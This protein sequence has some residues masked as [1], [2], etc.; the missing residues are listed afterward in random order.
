MNNIYDILGII[1]DFQ[2]EVSAAVDA[3]SKKSRTEKHIK[4]MTKIGYQIPDF[5]TGL[6][7]MN[8]SGALSF[9]RELRGNIVLLDFF[10]YCCVNCLHILPDLEAVE[11]KYPEGTGV[12]V[13][14]VHSAKFLN[15]KVTANITSAV[16][17][18]GIK[19]PVVN[20][21]GASLWQSLAVSCWPTVLIIGPGGQLLHSLAG[22][23][24]RQSMLD[25]LDVAVEMF[26]SSGQLQPSRIPISL[27]SD[28]GGHSD[29]SFPGKVRVWREKKWLLIS[30]SGNHRVVVVDFNGVVQAVV[31]S[32]RRGF[33][34][35]SLEE[36]EFSSPQG[37]DVFD[38]DIY[39]ADTDNHAVRRI[40]L[41]EQTVTTVSGTGRQGADLEGGKL[42]TQQELS[43]PWDLVVAHPEIDG[44]MVPVLFLAMSG[45]HQVWVYFLKD[46]GWLKNRSYEK[47]TCL[48][49]AGSGKEENRNNAYPEKAGFAQP[50]GLAF[51]SSGSNS[52]LYIADSES[53][54]V[55]TISLPTGK[56]A[57]LVGAEKDPTN[58]FAYGDEDGRG[59][60]AKLQHPLGV[61][62]M[63]ATE[64]PL[65]IADSYNH[66]IK[67]VDLSLA[68]CTTLAGTGKPG[69]AA[70]SLLEESQFN[71]PGGVCVDEGSKTIYVADTNNHAIKVI[72]YSGRSVRKLPIVFPRETSKDVQTED[73]DVDSRDSKGDGHVEVLPAVSCDV[74]RSEVELTVPVAV[75]DG[76]HI[77]SEAPNGWSVQA[78]D[79][80]GEVH[81]TARGNINFS[82]NGKIG[83]FVLKCPPMSASKS[84]TLK[85]KTQ[86]FVCLDDGDVCLPPRNCHFD[87]NLIL[88]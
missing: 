60:S 63:S 71:E 24:H 76:E 52:T 65:I 85:I 42:F 80:T 25:F 61:A 36:A 27:E 31:G 58:L 51:G 13:V 53:S 69:D 84:L 19:H 17:R 6:D 30:D 4:Q 59:T 22:E 68:T 8:V 54:S 81:F 50:S 57:G 12:V 21:A 33:K 9:T 28:K 56:V 26:T 74:S 16:L 44:E 83:K 66:K 38:G 2:D 79:D 88:K 55:R 34:D 47:G 29:L 37:L 23:G 5:E 41:T 49:L 77:N 1:A 40:N 73:E 87:Q 70:A 64:G 72:D 7:W 43:S 11:E 32:G 82:D 10:T 46:A 18:Y 86:V 39:L 35:G 45:S 75:V 15:E 48:R 14:G 67:E 78:A 3:S 62:L 20:D